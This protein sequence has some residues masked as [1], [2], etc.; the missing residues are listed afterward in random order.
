MVATK[1]T[2]LRSCMT[3]DLHARYSLT[4]V[5]TGIG[6]PGTG[7]SLDERTGGSVVDKCRA[8]CGTALAHVTEGQT[9]GAE[10]REANAGARALQLTRGQC[11]KAGTRIAA[12]DM[13]TGRTG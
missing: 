1:P 12:T 5:S 9:H 4:V 7:E 8:E 10:A 6:E 3:V 13:V 11:R 2:D